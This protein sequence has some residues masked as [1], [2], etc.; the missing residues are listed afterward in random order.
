MWRLT[1]HNSSGFVKKLHTDHLNA[2]NQKNKKGPW[3][4]T[5]KV[6]DRTVSK[7]G[8]FG[9]YVCFITQPVKRSTSK[10]IKKK[11]LMLLDSQAV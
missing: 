7:I 10:K 4:A 11:T 1:G 2:G 8:L 5:I 6:C 3:F 9:R